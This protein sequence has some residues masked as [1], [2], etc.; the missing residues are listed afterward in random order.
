MLEAAQVGDVQPHGAFVSL[1]L[2]E[3]SSMALQS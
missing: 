1:L 3:D 2:S